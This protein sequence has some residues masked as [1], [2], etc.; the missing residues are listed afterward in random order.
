MDIK[1]DLGLIMDK[2]HTLYHSFLCAH[3]KGDKKHPLFIE[4]AV[5]NCWHQ[6]FISSVVLKLYISRRVDHTNLFCSF[7]KKSILYRSFS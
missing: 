4:S 7:D 3:V 1:K 2:T 5:A 6:S